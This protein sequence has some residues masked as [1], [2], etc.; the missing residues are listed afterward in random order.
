MD[1]VPRL[2]EIVFHI[3]GLG[4]LALGLI[5]AALTFQ[6]PSCVSLSTNIFT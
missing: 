1:P 2:V 4:S 6:A 3:F 5:T